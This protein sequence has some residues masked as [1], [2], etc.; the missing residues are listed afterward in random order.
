MSDETQRRLAEAKAEENKQRQIVDAL[1]QQ[2]LDSVASG[3]HA[4]VNAYAKKVA[5]KH[6]DATRE[7]G[8]DGIDALRKELSAAAEN[9]A[10]ELRQSVK[11]VK[12]PATIGGARNNVTSTL[13]S[14]LYERVKKV[15]QVFKTFGYRIDEYT[16]CSPYDFFDRDTF[17]ELEQQIHLLAVAS[18]DVEIAKRTDDRDAVE[19]LWNETDE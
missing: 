9:L 1:K 6:P 2:C 4:R 10:A 5:H 7:L 14:F 15:D 18:D 3:F 13:F 12:W 11:E 19:S 8:R 17:V 16:G